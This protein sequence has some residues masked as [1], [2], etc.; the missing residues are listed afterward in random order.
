MINKASK[1]Y[2]GIYLVDGT[3]DGTQILTTTKPSW[4]RRMF[5]RVFLGWKWMTI[6]NF[7]NI[8]EK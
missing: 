3:V 8:E 4:F 7:K 2:V 1:K 5:V 6:N